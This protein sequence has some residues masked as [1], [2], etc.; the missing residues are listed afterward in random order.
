[1]ATFSAQ[2]VDLVGTFSDETAL[3]SFITA[4]ANE[5]IN[6][7]PRPMQERVAEETSFTN[8]TTSEGSKVLHVLRNDGTIDQP[9]RR[10]PARYRGRI[11]DSSDMQ[12]ATST[13]PAYYV[14]D[15]LVTIFPT[16]TGKLVSMPTYGEASPL[17]ASAISAITNFPN[18]AEY[19]V[20]LYAAIKALQQNMSGKLSNSA[21]TTALTAITTEL[22]ETQA[23][24]DKI[25]A[26]LVLAKAEVVLAKAE[27]AE[28]A[29]NTDNS[30]NFETA[31]DAMV[32]EL[33]KV[34]NVIVE[35]STEFD[36]VDNV[37]VEGSVELDKSTALLALGEVDSQAEV[38]TAY[39]LL[40][41]AVAQAATAADKFLAADSDSVFGDESTF[42]TAD[43][44]L[45]R[46]KAAIDNAED[47]I[48]SN[49]P[50]TTTDAYGALAAE[51]TEL[52]QSALAIASTELQRAQM[53]LSEW[54]AIGDMRVKE[55][56]AALAE[57]DG[58]VKVI[59]TH[60]QQAQAKRSESQS[61]LAAGGAY[62]QEANGI[63]AQGNAYLQEAQS[64]IAQANGYAAEVNARSSFVSSKSQAVQG[65]ISTAQSYVAT[66][67]G[68]SGEIQS[69]VGIAQGYANE[70]QSRLAVDTTE[71][72]W[73]EKQQAKLQA[74][75][76]RGIQLLAKG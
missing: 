62:L 63:I 22:D 53:H 28:I 42:L 26:D 3:D 56:N 73:Y 51:D 1:V 40:I 11:Q 32:T 21:I 31:C 54:T 38:A 41:T 48:N 18:E 67:Q 20:I 45:T 25:D 76:D 64:Y 5:V 13:D 14:Q 55:V 46:V 10:I 29:S 8:T 60:L 24:C 49:Q 35:A 15:A 50:S 47:V 16:G 70:V 23:V 52:V 72:S 58:Q 68:F 57:A 75:Y 34:D 7:M 66:A 65:H 27:A 44:Q 43:S 33:D 36:K 19:L 74:D 12:Y 39:A 59:Q 4:G 9:C 37:I 30:S 69:K 17:D 2:V 71:Y 61:R 6:A